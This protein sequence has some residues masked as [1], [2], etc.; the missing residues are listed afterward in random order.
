M[1]SWMGRVFCVGSL[2]AVVGLSS[3]TEPEG[4]K[5]I[6]RDTKDHSKMNVE[7]QHFGTM[8]DGRDVWLY[9][10]TNANGLRADITTYGGAVVRLFVPDRQGRLDD[11]VLGFDNLPDYIEKSP[12]FGCITGRYA[13]RIAKGRFTLDG[14]EYT[15]ATN[16]MGNHLHGGEKGFDKVLWEPEPTRDADSVGLKLSYLSPDGEEG[17]PGNLKTTVIYRLTN[18]NELVIDY[19]AETDKPTVVNLTNHSYWN[20]AGAGAQD[21]LDHELHINADAFTPVDETLIPTGE[22]QPVQNTPFDFTTPT[23]IGDRIDA[24][25]VQIQRG[26]GY[27]HNYVLNKPEPGAM[28]LAARVYEPTT[29]R[30]M[31]VRT[32]EPGIQFYSGNFLDGTIDGKL[33]RIY[34]HRYGFCLETQHF[35]DSPNQ[36]NFPSTVLRPGQ[37]YRTTTIYAFDAK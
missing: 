25:D 13:N 14:T 18:A 16:N 31:E 6:T 20:L 22:I 33:S 4:G 7:R 28:T 11:V 8:P 35:P 37:T 2:L 32:T 9:Q 1:T 29:G 5:G 26:G 17:Y 30:V 27:D 19:R 15:L 3:C 36:P 12:Y 23:A 24:D 21:I 34:A 10:L